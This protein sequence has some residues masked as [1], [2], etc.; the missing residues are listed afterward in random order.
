MSVSES[1]Y[2]QRE[3]GEEKGY[4]G[5]FTQYIRAQYQASTKNGNFLNSLLKK[6]P[7]NLLVFGLTTSFF[8]PNTL[9]SLF[10][11]FGS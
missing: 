11:H 1:F 5:I 4:G 2:G 3:L 9:N 8:H 10:L 6:Y 7:W